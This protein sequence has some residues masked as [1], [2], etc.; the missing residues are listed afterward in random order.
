VIRRAGDYLNL[1]LGMFITFTCMASCMLF[2]VTGA[3]PFAFTMWT[4][5]GKRD[6][7]RAGTESGA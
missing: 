4:R 1:T 6:S 3:A 5:I 7:G 2:D